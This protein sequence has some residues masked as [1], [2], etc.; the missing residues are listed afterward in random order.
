MNFSPAQP[1]CAIRI[2]RRDRDL[3]VVLEPR[4]TMGNCQTV[5][6]S[7]DRWMTPECD[8]FHLFM[9]GISEIDS[10]GLGVLMGLHITARN[11]NIVL[12]LVA[13]AEHHL[14]LLDTTRLTRI[15]TII[16]GQAAEALRAELQKP[17]LECTPVQDDAE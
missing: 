5:R 14:R 11:R 7:L 15:L 8:N 1:S 4:L 12:N 17:E 10:T 6:E 16:T 2:Y 3:F 9:R 13:P